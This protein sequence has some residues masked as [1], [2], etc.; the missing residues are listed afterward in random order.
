M[1]PSTA[2]QGSGGITSDGRVNINTATAAELIT[3][4]GIGQTRAEAIIRHREARGG[5]ER[6]EEIMNVSGIGE[7]IFASIKD[8]IFVE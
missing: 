5:F 7:S 3:L 2:A 8:R 6:I 4:S 1:P